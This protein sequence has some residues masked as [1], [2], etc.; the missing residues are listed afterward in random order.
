VQVVAVVDGAEHFS[1]AVAELLLEVLSVGPG[2]EADDL[3]QSAVDDGVLRADCALRVEGG[4]RS[5]GDAREQ[6]EEGPAEPE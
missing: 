3:I 4:D 5:D 1:R 6:D 2:G